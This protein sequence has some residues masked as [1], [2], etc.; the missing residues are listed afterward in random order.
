MDLAFERLVPTDELGELESEDRSAS[1]F[2][3]RLVVRRRAKTRD[4]YQTSPTELLA[5]GAVGIRAS[6]YRRSV[7]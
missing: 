6:V 7:E 1:L 2:E 5:L 4:L 3:R